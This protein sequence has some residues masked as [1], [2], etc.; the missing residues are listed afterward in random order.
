[1][2]WVNDKGQVMAQPPYGEQFLSCDIPV[3]KRSRPLVSEARSRIPS[4]TGTVPSPWHHA[5][6]GASGQPHR[7]ISPGLPRSPPDWPTGIRGT[8][9][10]PDRAGPL[11]IV[12]GPPQGFFAHPSSDHPRQ[13]RRN[14]P[15]RRSHPPSVPCG[16]VRSPGN[17]PIP[18][19]RHAVGGKTRKGQV[20]RPSR[21]GEESPKTSDP[22]HEGHSP[23]RSSASHR[24]LPDRAIGPSPSS[25]NIRR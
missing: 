10:F 7:K 22:L 20:Q 13:E 21:S 1:M 4:H 14:T 15:R 17:P 5:R 8:A 16:Q 23:P 11:R 18:R 19:S 9:G 6:R 2:E 25:V 12:A 24:E 3:T